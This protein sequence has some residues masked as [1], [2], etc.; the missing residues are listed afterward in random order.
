MTLSLVDRPRRVRWSSPPIA[1]AA[2]R[3]RL[4]MHEV[5]ARWRLPEEVIDDAVLVTGEL[6]NNA[7][8]HARTTFRLVVELRGR[9]L[10][11]AVEDEMRGPAPVW[12]PRGIGQVSG[13]QLVNA[14]ALRWH[15][16]ERGT[17]KTVW[18][19]IAV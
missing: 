10:H 12:T 9:L 17:G 11:V 13:L 4:D 19:D 6:V 16:E 8:Q 1:E 2:Y 15:W 3:I 7:V 14:V 18:A 5:L